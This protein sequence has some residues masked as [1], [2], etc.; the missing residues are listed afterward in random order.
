MGPEE[1]MEGEILLKAKRLESFIGAV[2][3]T[4]RNMTVGLKCT[5]QPTLHI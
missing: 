1:V 5:R 3:Q 4:G 2:R